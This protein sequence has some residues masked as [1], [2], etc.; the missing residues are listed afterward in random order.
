MKSLKRATITRLRYS[1][2]SSVGYPLRPDE[3]VD[4][5][6]R[7]DD[8]EVEDAEGPQADEPE[9]LVPEGDGIAGAPGEVGED[10]HVDEVDLGAQRARHPPRDAQ[11]F[12]QEGDVR[13]L[14]GVPSRPEGVE[15]L[16][17]VEENGGLALADGHLRAPFDLPRSLLGDP[18]DEFL[19]RFIEPLDDFQKYDVVRSHGS[20]SRIDKKR[21]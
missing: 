13:R 9:L 15:G 21:V 10:L 4:E 11:D 16:P 1:A 6:D 20:P 5:E 19:P 2:I 14:Q 12:R 8:P 3:A 7:I 17:V 18:V